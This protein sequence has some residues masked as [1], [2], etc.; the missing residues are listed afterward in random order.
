MVN[1][2]STNQQESRALISGKRE[3]RFHYLIGLVIASLLLHGLGL[4]L[5]AKFQ[6]QNSNIG[7]KSASKPIDFVVITPTESTKKESPP[8]KE[9]KTEKPINEP[10]VESGQSEIA[11]TTPTTISPPITPTPPT[12]EPTPPNPE[13]APPTPEP[14][15]I[16]EAD[17]PVLSGADPAPVSTIKPELESES[18]PEAKVA[19][20]SPP[21]SSEIE[22]PIATTSSPPKPA[23]TESTPTNP[24]DSISEP[25]KI[26][27]GSG[28][29]SLLGG[30]LQKNYEEDGAQAF[31]SPEALEYEAVLNPQQLKAL[32]GFDLAGYQKRLY[33]RVKRNWK[34]SFRQ[35]YTTWLTFNI[36][37]N[38]QIS[39]LQVVES[40]G[41]TEF[42]QVALKAV[43]DA[44]P[45]EALPPDFPLENLEFKYQFYLY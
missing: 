13:P 27:T 9:Q 30:D 35:K 8:A 5:Y 11:K 33:D 24:A 2:K 1:L 34:P 32:Q 4:L 17:T 29:A 42:D 14:A 16:P 12:P 23:P 25:D 28:A 10:T 45:L 44:V 43:Q 22:E 19:E 41:S 20:P 21:Q 26:A 37:K 7:K 39:Q 18:Q 40:S 36:E 15:K 6:T 31:F 38:G 3:L